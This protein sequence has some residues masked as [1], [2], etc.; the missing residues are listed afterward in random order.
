MHYTLSY[1]NY[2]N[3]KLKRL[4]FIKKNYNQFLSLKHMLNY[5]T[6]RNPFMNIF[7]AW[8]FFR[9]VTQQDFQQ[10]NER[11]HIIAIAGRNQLL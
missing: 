11:Y 1:I 5:E 8:I 3:G 4:K 6:N 10:P 7:I 9:F 2:K